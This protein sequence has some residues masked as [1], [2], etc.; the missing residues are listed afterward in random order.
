MVRIDCH[1]HGDPADCKGRAKAYVDSVRERGIE[2]VVLIEGVE[3]CMKAVD[4]FGDFVIPVARIPMNASGPKDIER[5]IEAGCVGIKFIRPAAPYGDERY[6]PLYEK[7]E[8]MDRPAVFHTGYLGFGKREDRPVKMEDMR[9]AQVEVVS[10]RFPDL[11][12][13]MSHFS[14]PWWEE[15]WKVAWTKTN[16]YADL[17]GGTAIRRS[18]AFWADLFAPD[19]ELFEQS[20]RKLCFGS[21]VGYFRKG[22]FPF[23]EYITFHDRIFD[24]IGLSD[25]LRELVNHG[26]IRQL[27]GLDRPGKKNRKKAK[28]S[29]RKRKT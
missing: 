21:D 29:S 1:V 11:R 12:I 25:E 28:K 20:I 22:H 7:L 9:A 27:L 15:A 16:V 19:G 6:W 3:R 23:E 18:T 13:L 2:A 4:K 10:R 14:N 17:S 5:A 24:R 26:T 8:E